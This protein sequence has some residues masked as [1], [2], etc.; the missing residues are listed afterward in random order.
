MIE[1]NL[2]DSICQVSIHHPRA[3]V[4]QHHSRTFD[5]AQAATRI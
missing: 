1:E 5:S 2:K 3:K 4:S